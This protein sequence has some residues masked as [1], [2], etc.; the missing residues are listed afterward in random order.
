M[1][2]EQQREDLKNILSE[3]SQEGF[4][5]FITKRNDSSY[6]YAITPNNNVLYI[7]CDYFYGY[8]ISLQYKPSKKNGSGCRCNEEPITEINSD[9]ILQ[10]EKSG[11]AFAW[12]L[13]ADL[14]NS[15]EEFFNKYWDKDNLEQL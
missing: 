2:K 12:K 15:S 10:Q 13:K 6:G 3:L 7:E 14:Y 1:K 5:C 8:N 9:I 4:E 11:L